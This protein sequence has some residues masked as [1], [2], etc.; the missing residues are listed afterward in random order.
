MHGNASAKDA[1][2]KEMRKKLRALTPKEVEEA[3]TKIR[4]QLSFKR[5]EQVAFFAGLPSEPQLLALIDE[6]P[7]TSWNL[8]RVTGK[9]T[10][11]FVQVDSTTILKRGPFGILEPPQGKAVTNF[12]T[13][14]CPGI[15]FTKDGARL[16]QGGGF[17]DRYLQAPHGARLIGI[18]FQSQLVE[19]LPR[20]KHDIS[21]H[22]IV[23][24]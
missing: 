17:Y 21:M 20:D 23:T 13:I 15:A 8:P 3:S 14:L 18:A 11:E 6:F 4:S 10:M 1:L 5:G 16:G 19:S 9:S 22:K 7:G 24:S 12:D 2:R